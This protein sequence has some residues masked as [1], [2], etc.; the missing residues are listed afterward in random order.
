MTYQTYEAAGPHTVPPTGYGVPYGTPNL[1]PSNKPNWTLIVSIAAVVLALV[2]G[3]ML[4]VKPRPSAQ[5]TPGP[6]PHPV[7]HVTPTPPSTQPTPPPPSTPSVPS[8]QQY[9]DDLNGQGGDFLSVSDPN[10]LVYGNAVCVDFEDGNSV[11]QTVNDADSAASTNSDGLTSYD[12]MRI[13]AA[14]T[15]SL[16]PSYGPE[17]QA[18]AQ[19]NS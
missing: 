7:I 14:A 6:S 15:T 2:I 19:A 5:V 16:C 18:W 3:G 9:L 13:I 17:V 4:L 12:M 10:L 8:S 1:P 11:A